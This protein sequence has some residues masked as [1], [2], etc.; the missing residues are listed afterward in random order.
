[1]GG[2]A[3]FVR[4]CRQL[5]AWPDRGL[6]T[7]PMDVDTGVGDEILHGQREKNDLQSRGNYIHLRGGS[8]EIEDRGVCVSASTNS[9]IRNA[10]NHGPSFVS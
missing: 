4:I 10:A 8:K 2:R 9:G 3:D 1:M 6:V 5:L 7:L